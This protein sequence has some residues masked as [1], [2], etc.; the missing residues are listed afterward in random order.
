M[1]APREANVNKL[2]NPARVM[3]SRQHGTEPDVW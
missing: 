3:V 2:D 1:S